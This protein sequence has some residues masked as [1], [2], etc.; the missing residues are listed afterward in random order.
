MSFAKFVSICA[1]IDGVGRVI[2][3]VEDSNGNFLASWLM[4]YVPQAARWNK[5]ESRKMITSIAIAEVPEL[6]LTGIGPD[7][8]CVVLDKKGSRICSV[9]QY[10][11]S[12]LEHGFLREIRCLNGSFY[13][14]GMG[15]QV[16]HRVVGGNWTSMHSG[17]LA[18]STDSR[19]IG[20]NSIHGSGYKDLFAVG[21]EGEIWHWNGE[22]WQMHESPTQLTLHHVL[23]VDQDQV[24]ACGKNG[25]LLQYD[26]KNWQVISRDQYDIDFRSMGWFNNQL[27]IATGKE[28]LVMDKIHGLQVVSGTRDLGIVELNVSGDFMWG[29]GVSGV[30][31]SV[32]G[33]EFSWVKV[34]PPI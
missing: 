18:A 32:S 16:Y 31:Y 28:L 1:Q 17:L 22:I 30:V 26:K 27:Y 5:F 23:Y 7:G 14:C 9:G 12:T 34:T 11:D 29:A 19:S 20:L 4:K 13:C 25:I 21:F 15:R 24:Y 3:Q 6:E 33:P 8:H 10:E 2:A